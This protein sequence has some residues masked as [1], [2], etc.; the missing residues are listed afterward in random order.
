[1]YC[2]ENQSLIPFRPDF[3]PNRPVFALQMMGNHGDP[4]P[5]DRQ[6]P[7]DDRETEIEEGVLTQ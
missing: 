7:A 6:R 5:T 2:R 4:E 3:W 1:V